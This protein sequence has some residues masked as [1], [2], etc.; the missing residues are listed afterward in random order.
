MRCS[1]SVGIYRKEHE[2]RQCVGRLLDAL[3]ALVAAD[4]MT[5][6][7]LDREPVP[8]SVHEWALLGG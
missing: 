7:Q 8:V 3:E 1:S 4:S 6:G 2:H 5:L